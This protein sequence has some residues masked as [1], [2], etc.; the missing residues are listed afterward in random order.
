[1][2]GRHTSR[3]FDH[4]SDQPAEWR[5]SAENRDQL[6]QRHIRQEH[7]ARRIAVDLRTE[8]LNHSDNGREADLQAK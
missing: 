3:H 2:H 5:L 1:M 6:E 8:V 4:A 7:G